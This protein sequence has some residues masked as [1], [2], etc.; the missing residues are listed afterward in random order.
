MQRKVIKEEEDEQIGS[1]EES[2]EEYECAEINILFP[3]RV[4]KIKKN[5]QITKVPY[6]NMMKIR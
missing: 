1:E 3:D 5:K 4:E 2:D 6:L